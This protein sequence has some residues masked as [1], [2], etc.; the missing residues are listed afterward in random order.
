RFVT[1]I[2]TGDIDLTMNA[3]NFADR[4]T[5]DFEG[6]VLPVA[7]KQGTAVVAMKVLG[8]A[9]NWQYDGKTQATLAAY[10]ERVIRYSLSLPG[11]ACAVIGMSSVEEAKQAAAVARSYRPLSARE[12]AALLQEGQELARTRGQYY[13][14]ITG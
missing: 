9:K 12:R 3:L 6:L 1:A 7:R 13:G 2:E 11:V 10:H 4:H 5:Y 8:G 14:P